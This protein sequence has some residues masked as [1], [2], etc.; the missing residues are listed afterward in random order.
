MINP[1]V[2]V[3]NI[4]H[5]YVKIDQE[6]IQLSILHQTGR[7]APL[8]RVFFSQMNFPRSETWAKQLIFDQFSFLKSPFFKTLLYVLFFH[9]LLILKYDIGNLQIVLSCF[10]CCIKCDILK[11]FYCYF[12]HLV[13]TLVTKSKMFGKNSTRLCHSWKARRKED[14]TFI[15]EAWFTFAFIFGQKARISTSCIV[16]ESLKA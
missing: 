10:H 7:N 2:W 15:K 14:Y 3:K 8:M 4:R 9:F 16:S 1:Q 12:Y 6:D 11:P 5:I 13:A